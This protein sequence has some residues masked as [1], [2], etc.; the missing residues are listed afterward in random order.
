M[1]RVALECRTPSASPRRVD[2]DSAEVFQKV[3]SGLEKV[4]CQKIDFSLHW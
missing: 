2:R 1:L 3:G 4:D